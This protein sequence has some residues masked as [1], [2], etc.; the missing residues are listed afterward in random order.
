MGDRKNVFV[1][2]G[3]YLLLL[4]LFQDIISLYKIIL[5]KNKEFWM[6]KYDYRFLEIDMCG[7]YRGDWLPESRTA[8]WF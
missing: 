4:F 8:D 3:K 1:G 2:A 5:Y 6:R 7:L